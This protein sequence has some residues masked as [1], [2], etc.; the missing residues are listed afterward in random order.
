MTI[1]TQIQHAPPNAQDATQWAEEIAFL[2][3]N[4]FHQDL[5]RD[6]TNRAGQLRMPVADVAVLEGFVEAVAYYKA[7][8]AVLDV[9]FFSADE[10]SRHLSHEHIRIPQTCSSGIG[11]LQGRNTSR[12][13]VLA[14]EA[15]A[16]SALLASSKALRQRV[17]LTTPAILQGCIRM[18]SRH[19]IAHHAAHELPTSMPRLSAFGR[20]SPWQIIAAGGMILLLSFFGTLAPVATLVI[21]GLVL[22]PLFLVL[23]TLRMAAVFEPEARLATGKNALLSDADLPVYTVLVPLYRETGILPQLIGALAA[24]DYPAAKL[25]IK[26]LVEADDEPLQAAL[27]AMV[28]APFFTVV[29]VPHGEP[30]TKPRALNA[31]LIEARGTLLTIFDAEDVPDADQLRLAATVFKRSGNHVACLQARL[32]IDNAYD[33]ILT[34]GFA[35]EYA[36]LFDVI[37]PGLVRSGLPFLMGGTSNHFRTDVLRKVGGW[38]AWNV[39]EDA[40]LAIRLVRAGFRMADCPSTTWEE[41][42]AGLGSWMRQRRRWMKGFMQSAATHSRQPVLTMRELGLL[43]FACLTSLSLGTVLSAMFYP[44]F[45]VMT[46]IAIWQG[47]VLSPSGPAQIVA[48]SLALT[49]FAAGLLAM[50]GPPILGAVRRRAWRLLW[51][52]PFVPVYALLVSVAAWLALVDWIAHP[53]H[54]HK[55]EHGL[56]KSSLRPQA[57]AV[58][59]TAE[60]MPQEKSAEQPGNTSKA[61]SFS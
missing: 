45:W 20:A 31:G 8:A 44:L 40:D 61:K 25:D 27:G 60:D 15:H 46:G 36:G 26:I 6:I 50:F 7:L 35:L 59:P 38:D 4:G 16:I 22:G 32:S 10:V 30:R 55:T 13:F 12:S 29:I 56:A 9:P 18:A 11:V 54:W 53:F 41:A 39:T 23:A 3:D 17:A 1:H 49:L 37:N 42:P 28:L 14:P 2:A 21:T 24:L 47:D 52:V 34:R 57:A 58:L 51:A 48:S 33:N 19:A 5:L 43:Q